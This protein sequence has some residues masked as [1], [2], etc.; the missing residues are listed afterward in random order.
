MRKFGPLSHVS[1]T[2]HLW[3]KRF[4]VLFATYI[5]IMYP[6]MQSNF[7]IQG[8]TDLHLS[9]KSSWPLII[10][11]PP[12]FHAQ[13][14]S[15]SYVIYGIKSWNFLLADFS[16]GLKAEDYISIR[17]HNVAWKRIS[18]DIIYLY[19]LIK[20]Q[21]SFRPLAFMYLKSK[22]VQILYFV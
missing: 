7:E 2:I 14:F 10:N 19:A 6:S 5:N 16:V 22:F 21:N 17:L 8:A 15:K 12:Q 20:V 1:W 4:W 18:T 13:N 3:I 11:M 9:Q